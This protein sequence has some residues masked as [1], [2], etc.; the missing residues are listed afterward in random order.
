MKK[1]GDALIP[2]LQ[3]VFDRGAQRF[4]NKGKSGRWRE[5]LTAEDIAR[6]EAVVARTC[7]PGLGG[8]LEGG[9]GKAGDPKLSRD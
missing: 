2:N 1:A 3:G 6:Y 7:T 5:C 4:L 8:W 9:R